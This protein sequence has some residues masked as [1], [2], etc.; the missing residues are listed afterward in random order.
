MVKTRERLE[1]QQPPLYLPL[2]GDGISGTL[3]LAG[4]TK[5][6]ILYI[7]GYGNL[8]FPLTIRLKFL[9]LVYHEGAYLQAG[10]TTDAPVMIHDNFLTYNLFP[11]ISRFHNPATSKYLLHTS[12]SQSPGHG[13]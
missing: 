3:R 11:G 13:K 6:A 9:E 12:L 2:D 7:D 1:Y 8:F 4:L 5:K 10:A